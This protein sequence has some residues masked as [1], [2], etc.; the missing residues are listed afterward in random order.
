MG[1]REELIEDMT[2]SR[3]VRCAT[4]KWLASREPAERREFEELLADESFS[5]R[6][7]VRAIQRRGGSVTPESV[8]AHRKGHA[9]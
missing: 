2:S 7:F 6:A 8:A 5:N 1:L 4:C 9:R 3:P